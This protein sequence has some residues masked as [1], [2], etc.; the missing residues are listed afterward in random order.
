MK[1]LLVV[2]FLI[3]LAISSASATP[4]LDAYKDNLVFLDHFN[5]TGDLTLA[6]TGQSLTNTGTVTIAPYGKF[7]NSSLYSGSNYLTSGSYD[8]YA[9]GTTNYTFLAWVNKSTTGH[10]ELIFTST[11]ND[12]GRF[13]AWV[14]NN[15]V[16]VCES[17]SA[18]DESTGTVGTGLHQILVIRTSGNTTFYIDGIYNGSATTTRTFTQNGIT[19]GAKGG[20]GYTLTG[21]IDELAL[22][23]V[24]IPIADLYPQTHEVGEEMAAA[25]VSA[26]FSGTPTSGTPPLTVSF[27]D[28]STNDPTSWEWVFGDDDTTNNTEQNPIHT[29]A[30]IGVYTVSLTA[31]NASGYNVANKTNYITV[32]NTSAFARQDIMMDPAYTISF[33]AKDG[34]GAYITSTD[35][36]FI[37]T[38]SD[39]TETELT[40]GT[41]RANTTLDY[42]LYSVVAGAD[43][44]DSAGTTFVADED[45]TIT[46]TLAT[47]SDDD[48]VSTTVYPHYVTFHLKEGWGTPLSDVTVEATGISTSTGSWDWIVS[49]LGIPLDEVPIN[50]TLMTQ[51]TDSEGTATFYMIPTG[52]YNVTFTKTGYDIN[53]M[54]FT[55]STGD[56]SEHVYVYSSAAS[57]LFYRN[58]VNE[59]EAVNVT[60]TTTLYNE[61]VA[62]LNLT[63]YDSTG[64]TT[65][66][67]IDVLKKSDTAWQDNS[68]LVRW[69][70][71]GNSFTNS[72]EVTHVQ[73][74]SGYVNVN[75]TH[76]DF[77]NVKRS[78]PF[79]FNSVPVEFLGFGYEISLLVALG[80]M[81][82]TA[83]LGGATHAR[84][85]VFIV[86]IE[87]WIFYAMHWFQELI[88]RGIPET[89]VILCLTFVTIISV[90]ANWEVRKKRE[91]Y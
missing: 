64:H 72:T 10:G 58:E 57:E 35:T 28:E 70:V 32:A 43:G 88:T 59:L 50:G 67:Y 18:C 25:P 65:G 85:V 81:L 63:Y 66:G 14:Y 45:K 37:I 36:T 13:Q 30:N 39:S 15:K 82:M 42:D 86:A 74:V 29:Y 84:Q 69:P 17:N 27:T 21:S 40:T 77:G 7:Y 56:A 34:N 90:L 3:S 79:Q 24:S 33:S 38:A 87:G 44:Y 23:N 83:M 4:Y 1:R 60:I 26:D 41:G 47:S 78:Y 5:L 75:A 73:Q 61:S 20:G 11:S 9:L 12:G 91:K 80:I 31:T 71:T 48:G 49:L 62:F 51:T 46:L 52:K 19:I 68:L 76:S 6:Q 55:A 22:W 2:S 16:L 54:I 89:V 8:P 53:P